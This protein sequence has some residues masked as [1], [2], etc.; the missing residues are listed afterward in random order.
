VTREVGRDRAKLLLV[1]AV[2]PGVGYVDSAP[3][4]FTA[5]DTHDRVKG[6]DAAAALIC[7]CRE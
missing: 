6:G 7:D 5:M 1:A 4:R 2:S 3:L